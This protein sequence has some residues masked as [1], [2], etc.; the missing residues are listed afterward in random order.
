MTILCPEAAPASTT[1]AP[2]QSSERRTWFRFRCGSE[3]TCHVLAPAFDPAP[4]PAKVRNLSLTGASLVVKARLEPGMI[5][6]LRLARANRPAELSMGLRIVYAVRRADGS[7]IVGGVF[8]RPLTGD[9]VQGLLPSRIR[10]MEIQ[11]DGSTIIARYLYYSLLDEEM[12]RIIDEQ[13]DALVEMLGRRSFIF[14]CSQVEGITS[15]MASQLLAFKRKVA[16]AGGQV[17]LCDVPH[18]IHTLLS[19]MHL[20]RAIPIFPTE[21]EALEALG[22]ATIGPNS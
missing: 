15:A 4:W 17:V 5:V 18:G 16:A 19:Q 22:G 7:F 2:P 11:Q 12:S 14:N 13:L 20:D 9:E 10:G 6:D 21:S 1:A 8:Q 3:L